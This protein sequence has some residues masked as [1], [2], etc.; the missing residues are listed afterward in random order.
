MRGVV[1]LALRSHIPVETWMAGPWCEVET[2]I[3]LY[4]EQ[5]R[6]ADGG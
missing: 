1:A 2:A 5:D 4:E 3:E 6:R